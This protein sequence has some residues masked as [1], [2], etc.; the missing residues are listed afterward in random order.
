MGYCGK[1]LLEMPREKR[2]SMNINNLNEHLSDVFSD[3]LYLELGSID[4]EPL[5]KLLDKKLVDYKELSDPAII[6]SG[7]GNME[8][9]SSE[10]NSI[11]PFLKFDNI[12]NKNKSYRLVLTYG[13]LL[14][15]NGLRK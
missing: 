4:Y 6:G 12:V 3:D 10:L 8:C 2:N 5:V 15:R 1:E 9:S 13:I 7:I 14:H 11:L